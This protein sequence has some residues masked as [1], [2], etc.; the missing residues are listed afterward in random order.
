MGKYAFLNVGP[1]GPGGQ[2]ASGGAS[3]AH[4]YITG[5]WGKLSTAEFYV[6]QVVYNPYGSVV[7]QAS[8]GKVLLAYATPAAGNTTQ[9]N[10]ALP[11]VA[12]FNSALTHV[13]ASPARDSWQFWYRANLGDIAVATDATSAPVIYT[14]SSAPTIG[15]F[16]VVPIHVG[17]DIDPPLFHNYPNPGAPDTDTESLIRWPMTIPSAKVLRKKKRGLFRT[18]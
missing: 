14:V 9:A 3:L 8:Q 13:L 11:K 10:F 6:G 12:F 5:I 16:G 7:D 17:Y 1:D 15:V 2:G 18:R 4:Y